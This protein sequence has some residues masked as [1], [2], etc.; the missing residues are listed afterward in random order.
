MEKKL[1]EGWSSE[2]IEEVLKE[3]PP[4]EIKEC[5]DKTISYEI[6]LW[7]TITRDNGTENA[8]HHKTKIPSYFCNPYCSW[9]KG[10]R[11]SKRIDQKIL[12]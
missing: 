2:Q 10:G 12:S 1:E 8:L 7:L 6:C 11:K 3:H 5:R 4:N 9:Q